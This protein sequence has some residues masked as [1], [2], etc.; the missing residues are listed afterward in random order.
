MENVKTE[1]PLNVV[2]S[3]RVIAFPDWNEILGPLIS[4]FTSH[5]PPHNRSCFDHGFHFLT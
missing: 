1:I 2:I 4:D 5:M 3:E